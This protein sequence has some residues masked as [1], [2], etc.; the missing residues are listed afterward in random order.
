MW[1][2]RA[3]R[4]IGDG[5]TP[6]ETCRIFLMP[7]NKDVADIYFKVRGQ[8]LTRFNGR[9]DVVTDLN[10]VALWGTID[11]WP[12]KIKDPMECFDRVMAVFHHFLKEARDGGD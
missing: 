6:C 1:A 2:E 11:H 7:E 8:T 9:Y 5:D 10:Q 3:K 12:T 4:G